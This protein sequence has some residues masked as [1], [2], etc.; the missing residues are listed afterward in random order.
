MPGLSIFR[1]AEDYESFAAGEVVFRAGDPGGAMFVIKEGEVD[2]VV[3]GE[4]VQKL[5]D[6]VLRPGGHAHHGRAFAPDEQVALSVQ[7]TR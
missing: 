3:R 7:R 4:V 5:G 2:S 6:A 1:R